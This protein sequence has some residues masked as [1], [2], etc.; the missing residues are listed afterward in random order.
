MVPSVDCSH[1]R[2]GRVVDSISKVVTF[3][4]F[5]VLISGC[6]AYVLTVV[7]GGIRVCVEPT[8]LAAKD[9]LRGTDSCSVEDNKEV[10]TAVVVSAVLVLEAS[11]FDVE[12]SNCVAL[13]ERTTCPMVDS[14]GSDEAE[15]ISCVFDVDVTIVLVISVSVFSTVDVSVVGAN[16][17]VDLKLDVP[18]EIKSVTGSDEV[19]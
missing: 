2:T 5:T 11:V 7:K 4:T 16:I 6:D 9:E 19:E 12:R 13:D 14:I 18:F 15:M 3:S 17:D 10:A 1:D 8:P